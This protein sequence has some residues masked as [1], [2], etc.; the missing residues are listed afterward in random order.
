MIADEVPSVKHLE[1]SGEI[2]AYT[3]P[4]YDLVAWNKEENCVFCLFQKAGES[5]DL[6]LP[7]QILANLR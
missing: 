1:K 6:F 7:Q 4:K 2:E 3:I 5:Y